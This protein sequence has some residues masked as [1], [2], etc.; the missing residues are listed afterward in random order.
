MRLQ[1]QQ[2]N[3][4]T[5]L[6]DAYN[7]NPNSMRAAL[8]TISSLPKPGRRVAVLG[9]M[10]ELGESSAK[11]HREIGEFAATCGLDLLVCVGEGG[12]AIAEGARSGGLSQDSVKTYADATTAAGQL[13]GSFREGDVVLLK[14]SRGV[15]LEEVAAAMA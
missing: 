9:E 7:A 6:N 2:V 3:G 15:K 5:L 1:L 4:V 14:G 8:E 12:A 13:K 11:Y 10:R